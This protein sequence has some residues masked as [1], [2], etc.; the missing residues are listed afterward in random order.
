ML[1][2]PSNIEIAE[3]ALEDVKVAAAI[4]LQIQVLNASSSDEIDAAFVSNRADA[5]LVA[6][7]IWFRHLFAEGSL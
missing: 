2:N 5:L 7:E 6:P 1:L 4:G 3:R